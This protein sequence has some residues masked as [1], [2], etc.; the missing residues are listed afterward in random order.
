M[1]LIHA[2][3]EQKLPTLQSNYTPI[4]IHLKNLST[5]DRNSKIGIRLPQWLSSKICL[6]CKRPGFYPWVGKIRWR[7]EWQPTLYSCLEKSTD[8]GDCR[9]QSG[10]L[11]NRHDRVTKQQQKMYHKGVM[12]EILKVIK[13]RAY[14]FYFGII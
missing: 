6:Q 2:A 7:R 10:E 8:R 3:E 9:L 5:G 13:I 4:K 12:K 11:Q 14:P 1:Q